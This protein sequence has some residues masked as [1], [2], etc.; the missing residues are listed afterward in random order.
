MWSKTYKTPFYYIQG[1]F[2]GNECVAL[3]SPTGFG[4]EWRVVCKSE[5]AAKIAISKH[6]KEQQK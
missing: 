1:T 4:Y 3:Y 5:Q 2:Q 6:I